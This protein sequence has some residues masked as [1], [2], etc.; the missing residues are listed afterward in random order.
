MKELIIKVKGKKLKALKAF[1]TALEI[2]FHLAGD[3]VLDEKIKKARM[4][5]SKGT[6]K[7]I[8]PDNVWDSLSKS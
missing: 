2:P 1:L 6:L 3:L 8:N 5:K 7:K 4:Q